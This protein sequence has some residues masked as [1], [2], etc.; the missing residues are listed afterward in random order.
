MDLG[1]MTQRSRDGRFSLETVVVMAATFKGGDSR[2]Q[3]M[4]TVNAL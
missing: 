4:T 3:A 2:E 1:L